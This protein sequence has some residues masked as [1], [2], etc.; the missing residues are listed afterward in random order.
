MILSLY[1]MATNLL[2][3]AITYYL[4]GRKAKGKE[5][6]ARFHER[7]GQPKIPRPDGPVI[8]I[9]GASV[10]ESLSV[11]ALVERLLQD[12][13]DLTIL[14]TT[15]TVTSAKIMGER[16]PKGAIHQ[17]V[18]VDRMPYVLGFLDHW[19]PELILWL[20]SEFWPNMLTEAA[21]RTIP[22]VLIN[23]RISDGSFRNWQMAPGFIRSI[24]K[25][26]TLSLGQTEED[27]R[28]LTVLGA[29]QAECLG[30]L[31]FAAPP[32]PAEETVLRDLQMSVG[33]RPV[34]VAASTHAGE[35]AL[36]GRVHK[37]LIKQHPRLLTIIVPRHPQR[38]DEISKELGSYMISRRS[39]GDPL[40]KGTEIYLADTMGELGLFFRLALIAFMGKSLTPLGGQNPLEAAR[41]R[42]AVLFGPHMG[43][44]EE[45]S[46]RM[47]MK[48]A[49]KVVVNEVDLT[50]TV[51]HLLDNPAERI[52]MG[53]AGEVFASAEA[54]VLDRIIKRL[55]PFLP[56]ARS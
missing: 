25:G 7:L 23:G 1:R 16:L 2:A 14:V 43:N 39:K 45:I 19:E 28:R 56:K 13:P 15:G 20:E 33:E 30:N 55:G 11:L 31:K 34:W 22:M 12:R 29:P 27:S 5:D 17:Y 54:G 51:S 37:Q 42:C 49:A 44:F 4:D 36:I 32:L 52:P 24:L 53:R 48:G 21:E 6:V 9:H 38:G 26:F 8:W 47:V 50:Q 10:G 40:T 3:P 18:P 41:L 35:E 46:T